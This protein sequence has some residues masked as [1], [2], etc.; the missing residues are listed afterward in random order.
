MGLH[1]WYCGICRTETGHEVREQNHYDPQTSALTVA[2]V[3]ISKDHTECTC[4]ACGAV[5][6]V[7]PVDIFNLYEHDFG[8]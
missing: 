7:D 8:D 1:E 3:G 5:S 6:W 2:P 4:T